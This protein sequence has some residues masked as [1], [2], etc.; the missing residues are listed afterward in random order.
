MSKKNN[1]YTKELGYV[2]AHNDYPNDWFVVF[3][4][5]KLGEQW[6]LEPDQ[7]RWLV[8]KM[9]D[10]NRKTSPTLDAAKQLAIISARAIHDYERWWE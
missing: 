5:Q 3:D 10:G 4:R 1:P 9:P 7:H 6:Y 8:K 2:Y